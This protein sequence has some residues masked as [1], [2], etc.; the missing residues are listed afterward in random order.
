MSVLGDVG[1]VGDT[2]ARECGMDAQSAEHQN[3]DYFG[4][5]KP[6]VLV[7]AGGGGGGGGV[8]PTLKLPGAPCMGSAAQV[9]YVRA[10]VPGGEGH[11]SLLCESP[12]E[13]R[14]SSRRGKSDRLQDVAP[15]ERRFR[16]RS[17]GLARAGAEISI[18][19]SEVARERVPGTL[20]LWHRLGQHPARH[21]RDQRGR[22]CRCTFLRRSHGCGPVGAAPQT[23]SF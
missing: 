7:P 5:V 23:C 3:T 19:L 17:T 22:I 15:R 6:F 2:R 4:A 10:P 1:E 9:L 12:P 8:G 18:L 20:L 13:A 16:E 21:L 11:S 14:P